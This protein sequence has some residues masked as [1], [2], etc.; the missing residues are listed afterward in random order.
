M[1]PNRIY[2]ELKALPPAAQKQVYEF[3]AF[4]KTRQ[5]K[6]AAKKQSKTKNGLLDEPFIGMWKDNE[7]LKDSSA[8]VRKS[9]KSE[10][11]EPD[12]C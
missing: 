7:N 8:W 10:W 1:E 12:A 9:R 4:L 2:D 5:R 3:I 11:G 6:P